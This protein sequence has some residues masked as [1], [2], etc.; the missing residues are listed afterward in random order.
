LRKDP[1]ERYATVAA[2][3]ADLRRCLEGSRPTARQPGLWFDLR[4]FA[5]RNP[6][7]TWLAACVMCAVLATG[8]VMAV[9]AARLSR[10]QGDTMAAHRAAERVN[11]FLSEMIAAAAP[12]I[13]DAG[14]RLVSVLDQ[15]SRR[16]DQEL[17]AEPWALARASVSMGLLYAKAERWA[18]ADRHLSRAIDDYRRLGDPD[19]RTVAQALRLLG[20]ARAYLGRPDAVDRQ[21]EAI[22][23]AQRVSQPGSAEIANF[24]ASMAETLL[25]MGGA[26][27]RPLA[28]AEI[29]QAIALLQGREERFFAREALLMS[30]YAR[31]LIH[32]GDATAAVERLLEASSLFEQA[33]MSIEICPY[34]RACLGMLAAAYESTGDA[35]AASKICQRL[36]ALRERATPIHAYTI[37]E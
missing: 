9:Y 27:A 11:E 23:I 7:F 16:L 26:A 2:L 18:Q 10:A 36:E 34:H 20:L 8:L 1:A 4:A 3:R 30:S 32:A 24:Q 17:S 13:D 29:M 15:T 19:R 31:A 28:D 21:R 14:A 35:V 5:K 37:G 6:T 22:A 33:Q 25:V 12:P